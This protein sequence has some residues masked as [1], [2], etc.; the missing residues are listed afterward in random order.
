MKQ[1]FDL[2]TLSWE[3]SG[4]HPHY[5]ETA[6]SMELGM[7]LLPDVPPVPVHV[8]GSVQ[9]ALRD[10][11]LLPD[12]N[13]GLN[14][15]QCE[16]VENRHWVYET[17]IP[18]EWTA[19]PGKKILRCNGLDY[20]GVILVNGRRVAEFNNA[21][22]P[23]VADI[24]A[25]LTAGDNR[26]VIAFTDIPRG[27]GQIGYTCDI[28]DMKPRFN[29]IWDW[30]PR[31]VQVGVW[32]TV[33]L[34]ICP[35]DTIDTLAIYSEYDFLSGMGSLSLSAD[36]T[37]QDAHRL[38]VVVTGEEG[39]VARHAFPVQ[40]QTSVTVSAIP[41]RA[42]QPNG[43]GEQPLY[44]VT[45]RLLD[46]DGKVLDETARRVGFRQVEWRACAGAPADAEPWICRINGVDTFL[47]GANWVPIRENFADVTEDDYRLRLQLYHDLGFNFLRVWGGATLEREMFYN[48]CD[49]LGIL[50]WQEFPLSSSGIDNWP[51]E[52]TATIAVMQTVV[53]SYITRRQHHASL[54]IWCGG[55]E[56]QG[57]MDGS[58]RG[59]GIPADSNH[60]M[61]AMFKSAVVRLDPTRKYIPTSSSG[62]RFCADEAE[63]GKGVH[64]DVHGPWNHAGDLA[65][66]FAYWDGDDALFRSETGM[67]G[68]SP[69]DLIEQYCD[70]MA[71]PADTNNP[72]WRLCGGWW[73]QWDDYLNQGGD[74]HDLAQFVTWSQTRQADALAYA[75]RACKRRFPACGGFIIWMGH[76]CYPCPAN[77]AVIDYLGRPKPAALAVSKVFHEKIVNV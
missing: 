37:M 28:A 63:F 9:G 30:V 8:P 69:V 50:V 15:R 36:V 18:A 12:W 40:P 58:K 64:H 11:G 35:A 67:P 23:C 1:V 6:K 65:S 44:A 32:D 59:C 73:I 55:N 54:V 27:L 60:P 52:D 2:S 20:H 49:E 4:W 25:F 45:V 51:P 22:V 5:W 16:W 76:D 26:L 61:L 33:T 29:Y 3:L 56:L 24:T 62:P 47:Q 42:W 21:Y 34:E 39:E 7:N 38:E 53:E 70:G 74:P 46:G 14:A 31:L 19:Q 57:G 68:C 72:F 77:T 71:L 43:N 48:L 10:A 13:V 75:V 41:A 66:W 17:D